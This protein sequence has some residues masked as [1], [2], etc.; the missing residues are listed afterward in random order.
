MQW[1]LSYVGS[2]WALILV[3]VLAVVVLGAIAWFAKNWKVAVVALIVLGAGLAYQQIDK[4]AYQRR[5]S[6][7][8]AA[9]IKLLNARIATLSKVNE[10]H[11]ERAT[12]D[13]AEIGRLEA[14]AKDTPANDSPCLDRDAA[15]RV[16][17]IR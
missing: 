9:E 15:E 17:R 11:A 16:F 7:E 1:L 10:E 5:V 3:V 13:A 14:L 6:E 2:T 12:N 8:K 4:N